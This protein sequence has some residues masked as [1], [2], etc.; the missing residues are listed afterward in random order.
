MK[1]KILLP[2]AAMLIAS[3]VWASAQSSIKPLHHSTQLQRLQRQRLI[4]TAH[5]HRNRLTASHHSKRLFLE[6][7]ISPPADVSAGHATQR[8]ELSLAQ[9][10]A[11]PESTAQTGT[12]TIG[13]N[14]G[15]FTVS[16][17]ETAAQAPTA[18]K[19]ALAWQKPTTGY[20][21]VSYDVDRAPG[22]G[23]SFSQIGT[24]R[25]RNTQLDRH[26]RQGRHNLCLSSAL[27]RRMQATPAIHPTPIT[28][29]VP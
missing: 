25:R 3:P 13:S 23:S 27:R 19:V 9:V 21:V 10:S 12:L 17:T 14:V 8:S 29:T 1:L 4:S 6:R 11:K 20:N 24:D 22:G 7:R 18:H 28:L 2:L 15:T 16:L 26:L 5:H